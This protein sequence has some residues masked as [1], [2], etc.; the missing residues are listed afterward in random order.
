MQ[1]LL[2]GRERLGEGQRRHIHD[3]KK[4]SPFMSA[5]CAGG[6]NAGSAVA[7]GARKGSNMTEIPIFYAMFFMS[8]FEPSQPC[9]DFRENPGF[10]SASRKLRIAT[11]RPLPM[12]GTYMSPSPYLHLEG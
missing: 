10:F 5:S 3:R 11:S 12:Y 4:L 2:E 1:V 6:A 8:C 7:Q 9:V